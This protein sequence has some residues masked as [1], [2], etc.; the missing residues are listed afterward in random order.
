M[1]NI[2]RRNFVKGGAVAAAGVAGAAAMGA[3][4]IY[5][6]EGWMPE[7]WDY[8]TDVLVIGFGF[9]GE[10]AAIAAHRAGADVI[11]LESAPIEARG[12][13][14]ASCS[15][16]WVNVYNAE[17]YARHL[18][19]LCFHVTPQNFLDDW[20]Q[21]NS[22]I[23]EWMDELDIPHQ[24]TDGN[25]SHFHFQPEPGDDPSILAE[26]GTV[27]V[28]IDINESRDDEGNPLK[29]KALHDVLAGIVEAE[30]IQVLYST[31]GMDLIQNP[32]TKEILGA[33]AVTADGASLF[34]K[35]AKGVALCCGG[36]ENNPAMT[37]AH[38]L[39]GVR[40]YPAG[41][42]YNVGDGIHMSAAVGCELWHMAGIEWVG[43]GIR[44]LAEDQTLQNQ[45]EKIVSGFVVNKHGARMY[46]EEK[47][48][49]H[50]KEFPAIQFKGFADDAEAPNEFFGVP[51]YIIFDEARRLEGLSA[52][53]T[54]GG[55]I[56]QHGLYQWDEDGTKEIESGII[57][58]GDTAE[59]LALACGIDPEGFAKTL[60]AFN[61]YAAT[62]VD[63]EFG[64]KNMRVME[65]PFYAIEVVPAVFNTQGG[66]KHS[67][68]NGRCLDR[69]GN[70]V[71]RLYA[72]GELGSV[73][74][75]LY[76]GS[77]NVAEAVM[78]GKLA[79]EDAASLEPWA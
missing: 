2:S 16:N 43:Y 33:R 22:G 29:G 28:G 47:R 30:G 14:S 8:E 77:G 45:F 52:F 74:S 79:G 38:I 40:V 24:K 48:L 32:T 66:P 71:P 12:G 78:T 68:L 4:V 72:C 62:G 53:Y 17:L 19:S 26:D 13:N 15:G 51:S 57:K 7:A 3:G 1:S 63:L 6:G 44:P 31:R 64:R 59:E 67:N 42:I 56:W 23:V 61:G 70:V 49:R 37:D 41:S 20:A 36:F 76:H 10:N 75:M 73:Y 55:F 60:E 18:A 11:V 50:T 5:A 46:N 25:Y 9:A 65:P 69:Y 54:K 34:I 21:A 27:Q 58:K 35:A 39:P